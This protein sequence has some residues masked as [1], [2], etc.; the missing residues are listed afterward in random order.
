ME[1]V[2]YVFAG[3][4]LSQCDFSSQVKE[5]LP[6]DRLGSVSLAFSCEYTSY[7]IES[8][9]TVY[10]FC[11]NCLELSIILCIFPR[12]CLLTLYY[13]IGNEKD[14]YSWFITMDSICMCKNSPEFEIGLPLRAKR[15]KSVRARLPFSRKGRFSF[16][17]CLPES[18]MMG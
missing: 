15:G 4:L 16:S 2:S 5:L 12:C 1:T 18:S 7:E 10:D 17:T 11:L 6:S 8:L 14:F 9:K 3:C 13:M